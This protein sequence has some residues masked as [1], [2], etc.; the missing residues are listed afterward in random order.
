MP[1]GT[2]TKR[3]GTPG[4]GSCCLRIHLCTRLA[5]SP[6]LSATPATEAPDWAHSAMT[7]ALKALGNVQHCRDIKPS[8]KWLEMVST[9][10]RWTP[11]RYLEETGKWV[12]RAVTA[13]A[14]Y[15]YIDW[16]QSDGIGWISSNR[17]VLSYAQQRRGSDGAVPV[18]RRSSLAAIT[19][20]G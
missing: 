3:A 13:Y 5:L 2:A 7:W 9:K 6:W 19:S 17:L 18:Y 8:R 10:K 4:S 15:G 11:C 16:M 1:S 14:L 12:R 20:V